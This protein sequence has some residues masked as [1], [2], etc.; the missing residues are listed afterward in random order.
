M[1]TDKGIVV[2]KQFWV[3]PGLAVDVEIHSS[4]KLTDE[5]REELDTKAVEFLGMDNLKEY[6]EPN[7]LEFCIKYMKTKPVLNVT[8]SDPEMNF[9]GACQLEMPL[10]EKPLLLLAAAAKEIDS[11]TNQLKYQELNGKDM[12]T[13]F[14]GG[15]ERSHI[16]FDEIS[17]TYRV[18]IWDNEDET[19]PVTVTIRS[20]VEWA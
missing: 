2:Y 6:K 10:D 1:K 19:M 16:V 5:E 20:E 15:L 8:F 12:A 9:I 3:G 18:I 17:G 14:G 7:S 13:D 4:Y 11:E